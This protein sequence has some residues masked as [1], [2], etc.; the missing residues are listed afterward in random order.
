LALFR[1]DYSE[2][3]SQTFLAAPLFAFITRYQKTDHL[4]LPDF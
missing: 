2:R 3:R 4:R 1:V